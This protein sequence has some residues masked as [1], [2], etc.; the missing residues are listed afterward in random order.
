[1]DVD[2]FSARLSEALWP[3]AYRGGAVSQPSPFTLLLK[4]MNA[5]GMGRYALAV[6]SWDAVDEK[7]KLLQVARDGVRRHIFTIPYFWSVGVYLIVVGP[8]AQW[9]PLSSKLAADQTGLH[10]VIVQAIHF[11]DLVSRTKTVTRSQ[12]GPIQFGGTIPVTE[13]VDSVLA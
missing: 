11:I 8:S 13:I 12:W 2:Q 7:F 1:M 10:S 4:H 6:L 5:I 3:T 9:A